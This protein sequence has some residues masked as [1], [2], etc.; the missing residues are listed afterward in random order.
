MF[1]PITI[2]TLAALTVAVFLLSIFW[3]RFSPR[4]RHR[5]IRLAVFV[6]IVH[7]F[8]ITSKW[9]T[10]SD[11]LNILINW[12]AIAGYEF[13]VLLF[14]RL[15]PRWLTLP[16]AI[17]LLI[18]IFSSTVIFPLADGFQPGSVTQ[19]PIGNHLVYD[20]NPWI[21][22]GG[23]HAGVDVKIYYRPPFLPFLQHKIRTIPFNNRECNSFAATATTVPDR[24]VIV[25]RCPSWPSQPMNTLEKVFPLH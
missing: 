22:A 9:N 18:P 4:L 14:T 11:R 23:G 19:V 8:F 3:P 7:L 17:V 20:V 10:T 25:G 5:L 2:A 1:I 24:K 13:L 15:S 12:F 6:I 21:N 16:S